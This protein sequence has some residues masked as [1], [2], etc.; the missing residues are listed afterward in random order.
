[1]S[2]RDESVVLGSF[3]YIAVAG[4]TVVLR[5]CLRCFKVHTYIYL[6]RH[7]LGGASQRCC[8]RCRVL[9]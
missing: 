4:A 6:A 7:L 8:Q 5:K 1:M 2:G 3:Q 9:D